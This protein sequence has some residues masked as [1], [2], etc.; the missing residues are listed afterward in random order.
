MQLVNNFGGHGQANKASA[1]LGHK[2]DGFRGHMLGGHGKVAFI[3]APFVIHQNNHL[4]LPDVGNGLFNAAQWHVA[5][6]IAHRG[7]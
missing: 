5:S 3:F 1:K 2:V 4:A 6:F 7:A